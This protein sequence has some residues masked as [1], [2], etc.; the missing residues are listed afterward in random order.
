M[1]KLKGV[2]LEIE[3]NTQL[4]EISE[5]RRSNGV[6]AWRKKDIVAEVIRKLHSK[7]VK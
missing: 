5:T 7:E 4:D 6:V 3:T 1:S 2:N